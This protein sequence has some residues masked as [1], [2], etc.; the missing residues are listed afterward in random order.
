MAKKKAKWLEESTNLEL[1][2][3]LGEILTEEEVESLKAKKIIKELM[4]RTPEEEEALTVEDA[5]AKLT[6]TFT[7]GIQEIS[8]A[9]AEELEALGDDP[10]EEDEEEEE[11]VKKV[12]KKKK[13]KKVQVEEEDDEEDDDEDEDDYSDWTQKDLKTECR[14]RGIKVTKSM[15]K[16]DLVKALEADDDE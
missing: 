9:Y 4:D 12:P 13:P 6:S 14:G 16:A 3:M 10:E 2:G 15:R 5:I 7:D 8:D 1:L 11:E